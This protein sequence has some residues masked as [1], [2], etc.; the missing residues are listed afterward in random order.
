MSEQ[1]RIK[2]TDLDSPY[3]FS[4]CLYRYV[5]SYCYHF[6][7]NTWS[8]RAFTLTEYAI[9]SGIIEPRERFDARTLQSINKNEQR[10]QLWLARAAMETLINID[11][12]PDEDTLWAAFAW[13]WVHKYEDVKDI[14][15]LVELL[16]DCIDP[17]NAKK[18]LVQALSVV[19]NNSD[20]VLFY[21]KSRVGEVITDK[22]L[23]AKSAWKAA[24]KT[25]K[26]KHTPTLKSRGYSLEREVMKRAEGFDLISARSNIDQ[27]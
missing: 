4:S 2:I 1:K 24:Q 27:I 14:N 10:C 18:W 13:I 17:V 23:E 11:I 20:V 9:N 25:V 21:V 22:F 5:F 19:E 6:R 26:I 8:E 15:E 7:N 12:V 3:L 16:P